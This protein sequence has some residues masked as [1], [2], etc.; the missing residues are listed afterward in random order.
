MGGSVQGR[1][2]GKTRRC[3]KKGAVRG[4][5]ACGRRLGGSAAITDPEHV[6]DS[7]EI[8]THQRTV[9]KSFRRAA[10]PVQ[11]S[12]LLTIGQYLPTPVTEARR[13][14]FPCRITPVW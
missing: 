4:R 10:A 1:G 6:I 9:G 12:H 5:P 3:D 7:T 8:S 2:D 11:D 13:G 14:E